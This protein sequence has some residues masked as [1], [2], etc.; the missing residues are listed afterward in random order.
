MNGVAYKNQPA[1]G[2]QKMEVLCSGVFGIRILPEAVN[3]S[4]VQTQESATPPLLRHVSKMF[5][6]A[7][8]SALAWGLGFEGF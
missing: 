3:L 8:A 7:L 1:H 5:G 2:F 4:T 6:N